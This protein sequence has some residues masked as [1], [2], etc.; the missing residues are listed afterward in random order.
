M[1]SWGGTAALEAASALSGYG[2]RWLEDVGDPHDFEG[3]AALAAAYDLPIAAGEALFSASEARLLHRHGGLRPDRDVLVFDPV[4]CYGVP[5]LPVHSRAAR[6][7]RL[8]ALR[9]LAARRPPL[10]PAPRRGAGARRRR[11]QSARLPAVRRADGRRA[12]RGGPRGAARA[13]G[14]RLRGPRSPARAAARCIERGQNLL[15]AS[16]PLWVEE[17]EEPSA[18]GRHAASFCFF[19]RPAAARP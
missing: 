3:L 9:L 1:N 13:A 2:L 10:L 11:A 19:A 8:A 6:G 17:V 4:H 12:R 5:G 14:D 16:Q 7:G 15:Y 18:R